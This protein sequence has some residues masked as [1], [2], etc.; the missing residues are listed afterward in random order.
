[1]A[2]IVAIFLFSDVLIS[3]V[4]LIGKNENLMTFSV[5]KNGEK[6]PLDMRLFFPDYGTEIEGC[7][8]DIYFSFPQNMNENK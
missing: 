1:M 4:K 5:S 6:I 8:A 7:S 2:V 3:D